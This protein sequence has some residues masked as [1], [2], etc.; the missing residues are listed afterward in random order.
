MGTDGVAR[1]A[2]EVER[3][4][5]ASTLEVGS[6]EFFF[7]PLREVSSSG[8]LEGLSIADGAG[9]AAGSVSYDAGLRGS[10]RALALCARRG[11]LCI[12]SPGRRGFWVY[13]VESL[14]VAYQ[15]EVL[16]H[17]EIEG[18]Y[19]PLEGQAKAF[20]LSAS[21]DES[22]LCAVCDD[23]LAF[24]SLGN[25]AV[26]T[27][28]QPLRLVRQTNAFGA[29]EGEAV[30]LFSWGA[31]AR[32]SAAFLAVSDSGTLK[33][34]S[35]GGT[36]T[37]EGKSVTCA[38]WSADGGHLAYGSGKSVAVLQ[39][40][41]ELAF[42]VE[43]SH[44]D[45][46]IKTN[47]VAWLS[48]DSLLVMCMTEAGED[49]EEEELAFCFT[50]KFSLG[51]GGEFQKVCVNRVDEDSAC[52]ALDEEGAP[53]GTGPYLHHCQIQEWKTSIIAH[54]KSVGDCSI[55]I[56]A[57]D[58]ST[59]GFNSVE[60]LQDGFDDADSLRPAIPLR[61]DEDEGDDFIV[62]MQV[63]TGDSKVRVKD[64]MKEAY[65]ELD[66]A[67][68]I[69]FVQTLS[70]KLFLFSFATTS[71][72]LPGCHGYDSLPEIISDET[73][74]KVI[75]VSDG[76]GLLARDQEPKDMTKAALQQGLPDSD[77]TDEEEEGIEEATV[78][79]LKR[80]LPDSSD[81]SDED[82][83]ADCATEAALQKGLP[84]SD[85]DDDSDTTEEK[86]RELAPPMLTI[87]SAEKSGSVVFQSTP[88]FQSTSFKEQ[89]SSLPSFGAVGKP[90]DDHGKVKETQPVTF[91][92][93]SFKPLD[94]AAGAGQQ[95]KQ[96]APSNVFGGSFTTKPAFPPP[97]AFGNFGAGTGLSKDASAPT[98]E[99]K[100]LEPAPTFRK[101]DLKQSPLLSK[102]QDSFVET[103]VAVRQMQ[104]RLASIVIDKDCNALRSLPESMKRL[105]KAG[106]EIAKAKVDLEESRGTVESLLQKLKVLE[107][108]AQAY[109]SPS[110]EAESLQS[111]TNTS[112]RSKRE[113]MS[114]AFTALQ[115]T[116]NDVTEFLS[117]YDI[118]KY[119]IPSSAQNTPKQQSVHGIY[120]T[121]NAQ[122]SLAKHQTLQLDDLSAR[123]E[124]L[125]REKSNSKSRF[126]SSLTTKFSDLQ[127]ADEEYEEPSS[128]WQKKEKD[129]VM[130]SILDAMLGGPR[131]TK[132][133]DISS[134]SLTSKTKK[135]KSKIINEQP[136]KSTGGAPM[137]PMPS[138]G[139]MKAAKD[140]MST[141]LAKKEDAPAKPAKSESETV[142]KAGSP[143][144]AVAPTNT[145]DLPSF[146]QLNVTNAQGKEGMVK[147]AVVAST[148]AQAG[149]IS[150]F[151]SSTIFGSSSSA[152]GKS[153]SF[154]ASSSTFGASSS[155]FGGSPSSAF[156]AS[157]S[158]FGASSSSFGASSSA[159]GAASSSFGSSSS[160]FGASSSA[161]GGSSGKFG[162]SSSAFGGSLSTFGASSSGFGGSSFG[163]P[164]TISA[165][166]QPSTFGQSSSFGSF[167]SAAQTPSVNQSP[168]GKVA[169]QTTT[170]SSIAQFGKPAAAFGQSQSPFGAFGGGG[171]SGFGAVAKSQG[172][173]GS[174]N[175]FGGSPS[176]FG[177]SSFG[178]PESFG[179]PAAGFGGQS[180]SPFAAQPQSTPFGQPQQPGGGGFGGGG[181]G[182]PAQM[183]PTQTAGFSSQMKANP[184]AWQPRR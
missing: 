26:S 171:Q 94:F 27:L 48:R 95:K 125:K 156:G 29:G 90:G 85:V 12:L 98:K 180:Q 57:A 139:Q 20:A 140:T 116:V 163:K 148:Q 52:I 93:P 43:L 168:F 19:T 8:K 4:D 62:G 55:S 117:K 122:N 69:L 128:P 10:S 51:S 58:E 77:D 32:D 99:I 17:T 138:F 14:L 177:G 118:K 28:A 107:K 178:Q 154:G 50:V 16:D 34:W 71:E 121:I 175:A 68:P 103:L 25:E 153:T 141:F 144:L 106:T 158:G 166:G 164:A 73:L 54:R 39:S 59:P 160:A 159:F 134:T 120:S 56:L 40:S 36:R 37:V 65:V 104:T 38:A 123:V 132:I 67:F 31:A 87:P 100:K 102:L 174:P 169:Q 1:A 124:E 15:G 76:D 146:G 78:T 155:A 101:A 33:V 112:I 183:N 129:F 23:G 81:G 157:S 72:S 18:C 35:E 30:R 9:A 135:T 86:H 74:S 108:K 47:S 41:F 24:Y 173:T 179:Q 137:P 83:E 91:G 133:L 63:Y 11:L 150:A 109:S 89:T 22:F 152:F 161:F 184:S 2:V 172:H 60:V 110:M 61:T 84:D 6:S 142:A 70:S 13:S 130:S 66:K 7:R 96:E 44:Q 3:L 45:F 82:E 167:G 143:S 119:R 126:I 21:H 165:F 5:E 176:A 147:T 149:S 151:G 127:P 181:F 145:Q 131:T 49:A 46:D 64:P 53:L 42:D 111:I 75:D 170:S 80:G 136:T 182:A 113:E 115:D 97:V 92:V 114:S 88:A 105:T 79:A 162:N